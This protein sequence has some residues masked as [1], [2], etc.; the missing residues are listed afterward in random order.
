[1]TVLCGFCYQKT[2]PY[3]IQKLLA[4]SQFAPNLTTK[5]V[6]GPISFVKKV[7]FTFTQ[8]TEF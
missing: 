7:D 3:L 6:S 2:H 8:R 5:R 4:Y 1:M